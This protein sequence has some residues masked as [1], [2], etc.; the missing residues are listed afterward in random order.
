MAEDG[1]WYHGN[2][3]PIGL[4]LLEPPLLGSLGS[5]RVACWNW[6]IGGALVIPDEA[7]V[8]CKPC[9]HEPEAEKI[10]AINGLPRTS[11][12]RLGDIAEKSLQLTLAP[13][14]LIHKTCT[15]FDL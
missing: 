4:S 2:S 15:V 6:M 12:S 7:A 5:G 10:L 9:V 11:D 1:T 8:C 13:C 14:H 3:A